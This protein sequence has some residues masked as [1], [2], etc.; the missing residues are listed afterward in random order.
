[1]LASL[2]ADPRLD[3]H[4]DPHIVIVDAFDPAHEPRPLSEI[5]QHDIIAVS[6]ILLANDRQGMHDSIPARLHPLEILRAGARF[7]DA[8]IEDITAGRAATLDHEAPLRQMS[9]PFLLGMQ[10]GPKPP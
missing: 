1:M 9:P 6:W 5:D 7:G 8:R 10:H 3:R 2:G 4:A